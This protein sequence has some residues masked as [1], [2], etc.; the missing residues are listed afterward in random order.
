[1]SFLVH[2]PRRI[3]VQANSEGVPGHMDAEPL[4]GPVQPVQTWVAEVDWW[5][6]PV[7]RVYWRVLLRGRLLCEIY[8]DLDRNAWFLERVYD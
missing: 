7:A 1:M 2:P 4:T 3:E 5:D 6:R 8:R